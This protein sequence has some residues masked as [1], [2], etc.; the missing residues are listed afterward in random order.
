MFETT[1]GTSW[2]NLNKKSCFRAVT[3]D[4]DHI[5][6]TSLGIV[7][8]SDFIA[9]I[10]LIA[11]HWATSIMKSCQEDH[12][13][14]DMVSSLDSNNPGKESGID[15]GHRNTPSARH[16][17]IMEFASTTVIPYKVNTNILCRHVDN[18]FYHAKIVAVDKAP[19]GEYVYTVH[20]QGWSKRHD[21]K[22]SHSSSLALFRNPAEENIQ[23]AETKKEM[24]QGR[25]LKSL[26]PEKAQSDRSE[27]ILSSRQSTPS[28]MS[29]HDQ[30]VVDKGCVCDLFQSKAAPKQKP[31]WTSSFA[32]KKEQTDAALAEIEL[33]HS[34]VHS[35]VLETIL[36]NDR[37][38]IE[39]GISL[40]RLPARWNV[41]NILKQFS[42]YVRDLDAKILINDQ[43]KSSKFLLWKSVVYSLDELVITFQD[44]FDFI[45]SEHL[46]Y[47][48][49]I[50]RHKEMA[51]GPARMLSPLQLSLTDYICDFRSGLRASEYYGFI[52]L[53]RTAVK[54]QSFVRCDE[55]SSDSLEMF[56]R[57]LMGYLE[58]EVSRFF[59][60]ETD[61]EKV[62]ADYQM[63]FTK[64]KE[65]IA[66]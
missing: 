58:K 38:I 49:E 43:M 37:R 10:L 48:I 56:G 57:I 6:L 66:K 12:R 26:K 62:C 33:L 60:A 3:L 46:L 61:Y 24:R 22:I 41:S 31:L 45:I 13:V 25:A 51:E 9:S 64:L 5:L 29:S 19:D 42:T 7:L 23:V 59:N 27:S 36:E 11:C 32:V 50:V 44:F 47:D 53:L 65:R 39:H 14:T 17:S 21:E 30:S 20:F 28:S 63:R 35:E 34:S 16:S 40:P 4:R 52:H 54:F 55:F 1:D 2:I 15:D 8:Y 18:L